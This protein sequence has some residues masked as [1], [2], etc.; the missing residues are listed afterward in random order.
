MQHPVSAAILAILLLA[1][2]ALAPTVPARV[3]SAGT[4]ATILVHDSAELVTALDQRNAGRHI[5]VLPGDYAITTPLLVPDGALLEGSGE[6]RIADGLPSGFGPGTETTLRVVSGFEGDLLTLGND[7]KISGLRL[8]DIA[9]VLAT[10]AL[11]YGNVVMVGSRGPDDSVTAEIR[12]CEIV[13]PRSYG[14]A[15]DGPAGH[16]VVILTR[17]PARQDNP[18]PHEGATLKLRMVRSIVRATGNGGAVFALNFASR[19]E[20]SV[21]FEDNRIEGPVSIAGGA[22]R[23]DLVTQ[24]STSFESHRNLYT[25]NPSGLDRFAWRVI[26]GGSAHIPGLAAPG[27]SFN[28]AKVHSVDDRIEGI[29]VGILAA[30]GR[31]WLSASGPV[32]DNRVDL[33]LTGTRIRTE[34]EDAADFLL[35][36]TLSEEAAGVGREFP[37]GDRNVLRVSM[38]GVTGS[39]AERA[40][41]YADV[42]GPSKPAEQGSGNRLEFPGTAAEFVHTNSSVLPAPPAEFFTDDR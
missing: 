17:N 13:N 38:R 40:N 34:G 26:G 8:I 11:R 25:R 19:G 2:L 18:P 15:A 24:A 4:Q 22:S 9:P 30:A 6:M 10:A 14:V 23:P 12:D 27:A 32:S 39:P 20:I 5:R 29:N 3:A 42:Y 33:D 37:V 35:Q 7:S 1:S 28:L 31:R 41:R 16:A 21:E 36:G